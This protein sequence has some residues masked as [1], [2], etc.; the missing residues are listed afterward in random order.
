[1]TTAKGPDTEKKLGVGK[2]GSSV[3]GAECI[4][5]YGLRV[6]E[7]LRTTKGS[8]GHEGGSC[9]STGTPKW[10][11]RRLT[12]WSYWALGPSSSRESSPAPVLCRSVP[13]LCPTS[14]FFQ[15]SFRGEEEHQQD[16]VQPHLPSM[17]FP[18][19]FSL[20]PGSWLAL[21]DVSTTD[22]QRSVRYGTKA[23]PGLPRCQPGPA[24]SASA[25][26]CCLGQWSPVGLGIALTSPVGSS[27]WTSWTGRQDFQKDAET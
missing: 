13:P 20:K 14:T 7:A 8:R 22:V 9:Q 19:L 27:T 26:T 11:K 25:S 4:T 23:I 6:L 5:R 3:V 21:V 1:M 18:S 24:L 15:R 12:T 2:E 16:P 10:K 17:T